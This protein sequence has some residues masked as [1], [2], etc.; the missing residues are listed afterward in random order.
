MK[1]KFQGTTRV[2]LAHLQ[3]FRKEFEILHMKAGELVNEYFTKTFTIVNKMKANG[4]NKGDIAV[5]EK[6]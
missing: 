2:K 1:Q 4:E 5:V 3:T 6:I